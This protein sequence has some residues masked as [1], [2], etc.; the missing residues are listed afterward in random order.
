MV[1]VSDSLSS[2]HYC[3]P[4]GF[5]MQSLVISALAAANGQTALYAAANT[6]CMVSSLTACCRQEEQWTSKEADGE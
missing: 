5:S 1:L 2:K 6:H 3:A 4:Y